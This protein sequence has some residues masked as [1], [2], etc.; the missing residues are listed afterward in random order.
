MT[1]DLFGGDWASSNSG[2][3][4]KVNRLQFLQEELR[5]HNTLYYQ[6]ADPEI[7][8][9]EFDQL[10]SELK[11]LEAEFPEQITEDSPT[12]KV[13][14]EALSEF[15][16]VKHPVPMLSIE[17]IHELKPDELT[18]LQQEDAQI[19]SAYRLRDWFKRF[20]RSIGRDDLELTVE[21]KIDGVAVS[22]FYE[23]G[24][25]RY[26]ATRGDGVT[27][28]DITQ[29]VKTIQSIPKRIKDAPQTFEVRGEIF[30]NNEDFAKM[31]EAQVEKGLPLF[32]NPRNATAGT[33]KQLDPKLVAERPLDCIFHSFGVIEPAAFSTMEEFQSVL[34][35]F[36]L[37]RSKWF[38]TVTSLDQLLTE[39]ACLDADR[40][41]FPY[42][43][44]GAVVKVN[45]L[46]L[47]EKIGYTSKFP[48]WACAF[49]FLPEQAE[50]KLEAITVQVGRTGVLTPVAELTPV[51]VSGTTVGRATLHNEEEIQRKDI[52]IGDTV[53]IEKA[54]EII[55]AV[56]KVVLTKR[57]AEAKPF[58]L[59]DFLDGKCP[60]C[61]FSISQ[62]EG[63]VA[64][65][66]TNFACPDQA[67][68]KIKHFAARKM[69]DIEG[70]GESVAIKLV[71]N[72]LVKTPLDLFKLDEETLANLM[73]DPAVSQ[74]G[75][76]ISKER[77]FGEKRAQK[78]LNSLE[79]AKHEMPLNRWIFALGIPEVGESTAKEL[80]RLHQN[81]SKLANSE[82]LH[83]L[84]NL[85]N[86]EE[87]LKSK[88]TKDHHP[89]LSQYNID[90]SLGVVAA[91]SLVDFF[92]STAG[93]TTLQQLREL[94]I[95]PQSNNFAPT[96][97]EQIS[98][99]PVSGKTFVITG[100]LSQPRDHFKEL[101]EQNGGKV[102]GSISAKTDYLLAGEKAGSKLTK[103]EKLGV[104]VL[105]ESSF[106]DL[107]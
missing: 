57:P 21:P 19:T 72:R 52:R 102:S 33:V 28:D 14:G 36:G 50:T 10:L 43:T 55:P 89:L 15:Q 13:G 25:L 101:I 74:D 35:Q 7:T 17:D 27:G 31:N 54:G 95:D 90:N 76:S 2:E 105:S 104:N 32:K 49:K 75:E 47:H 77:R 70:I 41:D 9:A 61:G 85:P 48:K 30:M 67:V 64:W 73:L 78:A 88:R 59:F 26:A 45:E 66:C 92:D 82:I 11:A 98:D 12:Q 81:L 40:H 103:A 91:G 34:N 80:S 23:N 6:A 100:T 24:V 97:E 79:R 46:S 93:Q 96:A 84:A 16:S 3:K 69:L 44:D 107:L 68:T 5:R 20:S 29:N 94:G 65:R 42:A 58:N 4:E 62:E 87:L 99:S 63:F 38:K 8:D 18:E 71:E 53:I 1:D 56:V 39:V 83:E 37:K 106:A 51:D 22:V 60:A 86:Y